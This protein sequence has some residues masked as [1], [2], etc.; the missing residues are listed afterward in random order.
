MSVGRYYLKNKN[1]LSALNRFNTV[2]EFYQTTPQIEE[3]LYRQVEIYT[4]LGLNNQAAKSARVLEHNYP[5]GSW[6]QK[7][8]NLTASKAETEEK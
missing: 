6:T 1:Y 2:V 8:L 3:A 5:Q 4:I 7:A